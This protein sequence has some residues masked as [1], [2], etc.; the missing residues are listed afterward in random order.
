MQVL[1]HKKL[2]IAAQDLYWGL[3]YWAKKEQVRAGPWKFTAEIITSNVTG[4]TG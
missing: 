3:F 2:C 1:D 4:D